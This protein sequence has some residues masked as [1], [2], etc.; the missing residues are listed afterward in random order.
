MSAELLTPE[1]HQML[2]DRAVHHR[3]S[4]DRRTRNQFYTHLPDEGPFARKHYRRHVEF[5]ATGSFWTER[6]FMAANRVGKALRHGTRVATPSGWRMIED[7]RA[8]DTVIA[9]SG[10]PTTVLGVYPQGEV[11]LF[12]VSMDGQHDI[13]TC[14]DHLWRYLPPKARYSRRHSHGVWQANPQHGRWRVGN[15][16]ELAAYRLD[17]VRQRPVVP[18]TQAF[19]IGRSDARPLDGYVLGLLLGDGGLSGKSVRFST[20]DPELLAAIQVVFQTRHV[21]GCDHHLYGAVTVMRAMGLQGHRSHDKFV[22]ESYRLADAA[23][24]LAVVQG[25]FDTDGSI[26]K[27]GAIEW[28]STSNRLTDDVEWLC[29]SLGMKVSRERRHTVAQNGR[30]RPSWRLRVRSATVCPFRLQRKAARWRPLRETRDWLVH[31]VTPAGRGLATC[32]AVAHP[33]HTFVIEHGVVTHNTTSGGFEAAVHATGLYSHWWPG[34]RFTKPTR[35]WACGTTTDK[36]RDIVQ[37]MLVG[38]DTTG[39]VGFIPEELIVKKTRRAHAGPGTYDTVY[40]RHVSGGVSRITFKSYEQGRKAFESAELEWVWDDEEPPGDVYQEQVLRLLTTSGTI[41]L[42]FTPLAGISDVVKGYIEPEN[43]SESASTKIYI[44]AGWDDVPHLDEEM[45]ARTIA[46]MLPYQIAARTKGEPTLGSGAIYPVTEDSIKVKAFAIPDH[47]PR[48]YGMDVGWLR[49]AAP[50]VA[51]DPG[52]GIYYVYSLHYV[53]A[54]NPSAH[55][56]AIKARGDWM[57]GAIDPA[58]RGRSQSDGQA[59]MDTYNE[60]GLHL[61]KADNAVDAGIGE[62][63]EL[64]ISGRL[65][66]FD[67]LE[68]FWREFRKYH[69]NEKGVIVKGNDHALDGLRYWVMSGRNIMRI[70]PPLPKGALVRTADGRTRR[71]GSWM[72]KA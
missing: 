33:S 16:R 56:D 13:V 53:S 4:V 48:S 47:W 29:V 10:E 40:V 8:G 21:A 66:I 69:R 71:G 59:L 63:W 67:S 30:G 65:K 37:A 27:T 18:H 72:G 31:R 70:A 62:V 55:A 15:T 51:Q 23:T 7:L 35:G 36:T 44:Q 46:T 12:A 3:M 32:I 50:F 25:L 2:R 28:A 26:S 1:E 6:C 9:G 5:Y 39:E 38:N 49:T 64:F 19:A 20:E 22:P 68:D 45:K 61:V 43:A 41:F 17:S 14:G 24:R 54:A 57:Q 11:D 52:S 34:K 60:L 58:S 42:T